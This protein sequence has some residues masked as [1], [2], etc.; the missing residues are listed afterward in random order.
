MKIINKAT[1]GLFIFLL[2][3][4]AACEAKESADPTLS[5]APSL[6]PVLDSG[7]WADWNTFDGVK[8]IDNN[9]IL[10]VGGP[11]EP[12]RKHPQLRNASVWEI[13]KGVTVLSKAVQHVGICTHDGFLAYTLTY[14]KTKTERFEGKFGQERIFT[15]PTEKNASRRWMDCR[16]HASSISNEKLEGPRQHK[17]TFLLYSH[18]YLDY[19]PRNIDRPLGKK[20]D[21]I[22][23]YRTGQKEPVSLPITNE[24]IRHADYY[25]FKDAYFI[26]PFASNYSTWWLYPDGRMEEIKYPTL[27][28]LLVQGTF[29][30][31]R[32]GFFIYYYDGRPPS[33]KVP[34]N[35]GGYLVAEDGKSS[36]V[37]SGYLNGISVSPDGCKVA[38]THYPYLDATRIDDP[39]R[40]T[41]KA[42]NL[43]AEE[44]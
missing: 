39:G 33:F 10:F 28:K 2:A 22:L 38:F 9:R 11:D 20:G 24:G 42:I 4:L 25:P 36:K 3:A 12:G 43:C 27:P 41:L 18:G 29:F 26:H 34:G 5:A 40:V 31:I 6:Y 16:F 15:P 44:K 37:I 17:L 21:P 1:V 30:P 35:T 7:V 19:G 13:G 14:D 8:W 32:K 23:Y